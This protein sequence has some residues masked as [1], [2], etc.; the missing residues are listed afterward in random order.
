[1]T[2]TPWLTIVGVGENGADGLCGASRAA[3]DAAQWII[4]P[5]RHLALIDGLGARAAERLVWPAPFADGLALVE[6]RRGR[7]GVVLA[8]GDPF[9]F[10][11]GRSL[12]R[13]LAAGEWRALPGPSS[14]SLAAARLGWGLE[15]TLCLGL[16]AAPVT[17]LRPRLAPGVRALVLVRDGA[18]FADL[19]QWLCDRGFAATRLWAMEALGGPRERVRAATAEAVAGQAVW[20]ADPPAHPVC[21]ALDMACDPAPAGG[22]AE[23]V[24]GGGALLV[25]C[26]SG[27]PDALFDHDG[28]ITKRPVRALTLSALCPR[29]GEHLWDIGSGSGSVAIEWLACHASLRAT[30][31]EADATRARRLAANACALG[32]DRLAV[33]HGRAPEVL[34]DL[35]AP[36]DRPDAVFIGGGLSEALLDVLWQRLGPGGRLVANAVTLE[37]EALLG[38]WQRTVGGTLLRVALSEARPLGQRHAWAAAYP[39]VQW[40]VV[41]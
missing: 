19:A 26:A 34:A 25:P 23:R 41:R 11:A 38:R 28:Q 14:F 30:A 4:G 1:M 12:A 10:G 37:S 27:W 20:A 9:W 15:E 29:A 22:G 36:D 32:A 31:V 33:V 13:R 18:A 40:S 8:S 35:S 16:H 5:P 6:A 24:A 39:I 7:P 21:A 2:D 3:L 17:R